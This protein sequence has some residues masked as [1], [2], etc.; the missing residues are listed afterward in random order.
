ML[1]YPIILQSMPTG[2]KLITQKKNCQWFIQK[3]V[4]D[5]P[6]TRFILH[7]LCL[8]MTTTLRCT[9]VL[10]LLSEGLAID[11]EYDGDGDHDRS[12]T[13]QQSRCPLHAHVSEH[14]RCKQRKASPNQRPEHHV[15]RECRCRTADQLAKPYIAA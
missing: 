15:R 2:Y 8:P 6:H 12:D 9:R 1:F 4:C 14:L 7:Y 11:A 3:D 13:A 10:T 5:I